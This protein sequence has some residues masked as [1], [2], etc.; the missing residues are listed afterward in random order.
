MCFPARA[1][2]DARLIREGPV[3]QHGLLV[4]CTSEHGAGAVD[5]EDLSGKCAAGEESVHTV[6]DAPC[7]QFVNEVETWAR[8]GD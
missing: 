4:G 7:V 5:R 8:A 1:I 2:E 6:L 3:E